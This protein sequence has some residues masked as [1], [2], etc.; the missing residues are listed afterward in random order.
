MKKNL[1]VSVF[2]VSL[3]AAS[4][5]SAQCPSGMCCQNGYYYYNQPAAP[6]CQNGNCEKI[7]APVCQNGN[8]EKIAAPVCQNG[9]YALNCCNSRATER[10]AP[11][12]DCYKNC[13]GYYNS[14]GWCVARAVSAPF[15][16]I[17]SL[18]CR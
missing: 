10:Y 1:F 13:G 18:F 8:C 12:Y 3:L 16:A 7:A 2:A 15:R 6:V 4:A 14:N 9:N 11:V 5:A 17:R